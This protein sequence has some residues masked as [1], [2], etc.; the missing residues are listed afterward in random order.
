MNLVP[1][2]VRGIFMTIKGEGAAPTVVLDVGDDRSIPIYIG[3]W[4]GISIHNA[5]EGEVSP[6]PITHD[7]FLDFMEKYSISLESLQIDSLEDGIFYSRLLF[8]RNGQEEVLDCRPS[9]GIAI[10]IRADAPIYVDERV[11][12]MAALDHGDL[13]DLRDI[14]VIL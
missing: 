12:D 5:L 9:D 8:V 14:S 13:G 2:R 3:L 10:A 7:L 6:R 4:E 11:I 1:C